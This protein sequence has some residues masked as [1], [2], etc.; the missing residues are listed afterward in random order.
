MASYRTGARALAVAVVITALAAGIGGC[1]AGAHSAGRQ[2]TRAA[3]TTTAITPKRC[4][5]AATCWVLVS[6]ATLWASPHAPRA[7]DQPALA[8]PAQ[9]GAWVADMT[10]A[11]KTGLGGRVVSQA[12]YGT[13]VIV[14][15]RS[16]ASWTKIAVPSQPTNLDSRGYPGWVPTGQLTSTAPGSAR[17]QA[18]VSTSTAWLWSGWAGTSGTGRR[19]MDLSYDTTLPVLRATSTHVEVALIGGRPAELAR[20]SVTLHVVGSPWNATGA[21]LVAQARKFLGLQYLWGGT[22]GFGFDCSGLTHSIYLA[23]GVVIPR[24]ADRQAAAGTPVA[25]TALQ[26]GDLVFFYDGSVIGHVG[27]YI[28]NGDMIDAPTTGSPARIDPVF[29]FGNYAGARRYLPD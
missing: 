22:S 23:Y 11:D 7:V 3:T 24:D 6:V 8:N 17:T 25:W 28:G 15:G 16:G 21:K 29:S 4:A 10:Y 14:I 26:P 1:G 19:L 12:L 9:P 13:R 2:G 20:G 27:I 5:S 18:L